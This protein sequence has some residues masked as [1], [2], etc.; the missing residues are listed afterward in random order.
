MAEEMHR[1]EHD[2]HGAE[3]HKGHAAEHTTHTHKPELKNGNMWIFWILLALVLVA[4]LV[5]LLTC[6]FKGCNA[7][8]Q[9]GNEEQQTTQQQVQQNLNALTFTATGNQPCSENGKPLVMLFSTTWCPH[10]QWI[11]DTF[12]STA[13]S[14]GDKI[15]AYHW[16]IDTGDNTLTDAAETK[17]PAELLAYYQKYNPKGSI[18]TFVFGCEYTRIGNGYERQGDLAAEENEFRAIIDGLVKE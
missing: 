1:K 6:G 14:Y 2:M 11:K 16:E 15:A 8:E 9:T 10:C 7:K 12:D 18:P 5:S 13:K 17:V 3:K 4:L